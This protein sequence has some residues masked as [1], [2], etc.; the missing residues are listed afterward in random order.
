MRKKFRQ[1]DKALRLGG[2]DQ[3]NRKMY[4]GNIYEVLSEENN[5]GAF[6]VGIPGNFCAEYF[7]VVDEFEGNI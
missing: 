7:R 2:E 1:G 3:P 5:G 6:L 4:I